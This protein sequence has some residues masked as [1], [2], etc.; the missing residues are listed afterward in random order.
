MSQ[1]RFSQLTARQQEL[2]RSAAAR[3][4]PYMRTLWDSV[5]ASSQAA[6]EKKGVRVTEVDTAAFRKAAATVLETYVGGDTSLMTLYERVR[7]LA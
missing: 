3:S 1:R 7:A 2:V 6:V 5:E 4:V